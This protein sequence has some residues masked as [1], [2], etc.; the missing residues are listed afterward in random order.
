MRLKPWLLAHQLHILPPISFNP[1]TQL[2]C[3]PTADPTY[4]LMKTSRE[5]NS[6][7]VQQSAPSCQQSPAILSTYIIS[8]ELRTNPLIM[9]AKTQRNVWTLVAKF[10]NSLSNSKILLFSAFLLVMS[11]K[12]LSRCPSL[13]VLLGRLPS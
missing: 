6:Q 11:Y 13:A 9:Q 4:K 2:R 5:E 1:H 10:A 7:P 3:S 8:P 12:S